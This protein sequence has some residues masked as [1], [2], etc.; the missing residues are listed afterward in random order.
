M[1]ADGNVIPAAP[2][3]LMQ[4]NEAQASSGRADTR[5]MAGRRRFCS[6]RLNEQAQYAWVRVTSLLW[7]RTSGCTYQNWCCDFD[8]DLISIFCQLCQLCQ[9][10]GYIDFE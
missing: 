10:V 5:R 6:L 8:A 9:L 1:E 4:M 7:S 3:D 2:E